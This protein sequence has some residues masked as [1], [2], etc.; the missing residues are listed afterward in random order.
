MPDKVLDPCLGHD[1]SN[2]KDFL[3]TSFG[4][5]AYSEVPMKDTNMTKVSYLLFKY[6]CSGT[7]FKTGH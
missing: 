1:L 3:H 6:F 5:A 2:K 4:K 7:Q